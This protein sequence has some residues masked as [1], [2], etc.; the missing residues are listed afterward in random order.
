MAYELWDMQTANLVGDYATQEDALEDVRQTLLTSGRAAIEP[1]SLA[2]ETESGETRS[3]AS[4]K[5]LIE[6]AEMSTPLV[7]VTSANRRLTA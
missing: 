2:F 7:G 1:L 4:G 5:S 3:I 6:L